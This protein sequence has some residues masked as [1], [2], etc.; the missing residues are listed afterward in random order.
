[1]TVQLIFQDSELQ[2]KV[3]TTDK[4]NRFKEVLYT[5]IASKLPTEMLKYNSMN[6]LRK[7]L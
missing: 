5:L 4:K 3:Y 1:M 7:K 2:H 6:I